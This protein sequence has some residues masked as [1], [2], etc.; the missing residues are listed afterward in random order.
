MSEDLLMKPCFCNEMEDPEVEYV[1]V[2]YDRICYLLKRYY[3]YKY[4]CKAF[5]HIRPAL[6]RLLDNM[7]KKNSEFYY[8]LENILNCI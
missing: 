2:E 5:Y 6:Y 4:E 8:Q 1:S 3:N 7:R